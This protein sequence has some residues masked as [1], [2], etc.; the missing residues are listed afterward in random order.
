MNDLID[1]ILKKKRDN[2]AQGRDF[3]KEKQESEAA[4]R[5][6][7][8]KKE[9]KEKDEDKKAEESKDSYLTTEQYDFIYKRINQARKSL[10]D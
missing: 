2:Q 9:R 8:K 5:K 1:G 6:L 7:E 3:K 4:Q 10:K